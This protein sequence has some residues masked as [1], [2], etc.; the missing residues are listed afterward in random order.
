MGSGVGPCRGWPRPSDSKWNTPAGCQLLLLRHPAA[1][2]PN[3]LLAPRLPPGPGRA[4][5]P[6]GAGEARPSLL[7]PRQQLPGSSGTCGRWPGTVRGTT[8]TREEGIMTEGS[9][10]AFTWSYKLLKTTN[11]SHSLSTRESLLLSPKLLTPRRLPPARPPAP[12]PLRAR[13]ETEEQ[14]LPPVT[15]GTGRWGKK[16]GRG[17]EG[18]KITKLREKGKRPCALIAPEPGSSSRLGPPRG[19]PAIAAGAG[20]DDADDCLLFFGLFFFFSFTLLS[21]NAKQINPPPSAESFPLVLSVSLILCSWKLHYSDR[22]DSLL[23]GCNKTPPWLLKTASSAPHSEPRIPLSD[24][25]LS[26][27]RTSGPPGGP[28][29]GRESWLRR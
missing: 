1:Q 11:T 29:V 26:E 2:R 7:I 22:C 16:K 6:A 27:P 19:I 5:R 17:R 14:P 8:D 13:S 10:A 4:W 25:P 21:L 24:A 28:A 9:R 3:R 23:C 20:A 12:C 18:T 15:A